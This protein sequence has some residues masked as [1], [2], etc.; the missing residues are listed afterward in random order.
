MKS[1][2]AGACEIL[3]E[4]SDWGYLAHRAIVGT[5]PWLNRVFKEFGIH[6]KKH[7][8]PAKVHKS[9]EDKGRKA[10]AKNVTTM[11]AVMKRKGVLRP[12]S[13]PRGGRLGLLLLPPPPMRPRLPR[14]MM[15]TRLPRTLAEP[16]ALLL[17]EREA[18]AL[19]PPWILA[20]MIW[21][22]PP[23]KVQTVALL[24]NPLPWCLC[25]AFWVTKLPAPRAMVVV[26]V[27]LLRPERGRRWYWP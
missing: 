18:S 13:L 12:R 8:V 2:E 25:P 7:D 17:L 15:M 26:V 20:V 6:H 14:L 24:L 9:I 16:L 23:S 21:W 1:T 22:I 3:G 19:L 11:A 27:M 5:M 4:M 10:A